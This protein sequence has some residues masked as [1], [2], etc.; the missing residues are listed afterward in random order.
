MQNKN[1]LSTRLNSYDSGYWQEENFYPECHALVLP[2]FINP[3]KILLPFLEVLIFWVELERNSPFKITFF[4]LFLFGWFRILKRIQPVSIQYDTFL[5]VSSVSEGVWLQS[6]KFL[7]CRE[8]SLSLELPLQHRLQ[9]TLQKRQP[10]GATT[11]LSSETENSKKR[12]GPPL[13]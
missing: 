4:P 1:Q 7:F 2:P 12:D 9:D 8:Q 6:V 10:Q 5:Q 13:I 3:L 11:R